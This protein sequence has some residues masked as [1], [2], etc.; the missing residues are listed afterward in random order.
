MKRIFLICIICVSCR[1][2]QEVSP[3]QAF[4]SA[5]IDGKLWIPSNPVAYIDKRNPTRQV[6]VIG[7]R[8]GNG[9]E[10]QLFIFQPKK[11][12]Y[13]LDS[14]SAS[15]ARYIPGQSQPN[16]VYSTLSSGT[17]EGL[18]RI[19]YYDEKYVSGTFYFIAYNPLDA[20]WVHVLE[21]TFKNISVANFVP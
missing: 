18:I 20:T 3:T 13:F 5:E 21:G 7:A 15:Y 14:F 17:T 9:E 6:L 10:I 2:S 8:E 11:E 12:D 19:T 1:S 4:L 16:A